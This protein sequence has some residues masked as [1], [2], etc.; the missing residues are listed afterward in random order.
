M[1]TVPKGKNESQVD[2]AYSSKIA[3]FHNRC[4]LTLCFAVGIEQ[5]SRS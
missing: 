4:V 3:A 1:Y 5:H 2:C